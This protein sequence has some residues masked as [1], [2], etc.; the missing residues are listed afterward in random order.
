MAATGLVDLD[1]LVGRDPST[2]A[3]STVETLKLHAAAIGARSLVVSSLRAQYFDMITGNAEASAI[4]QSE[5]WRSTIVLDLRDPRKCLEQLDPANESTI[6]RIAPQLHGLDPRSRTCRTIVEAA[7]ARGVLFLVEG[8]FRTVGDPFLDFSSRAV[9]LDLHFYHLGDFLLVAKGHD[10]AMA[11]TRLLNSP[12]GVER[13]V[14]EL[15]AHRLLF[16]SRCPAFEARAAQARLLGANISGADRD[17]I[18]FR[19]AIELGLA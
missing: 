1:T 4:A 10:N 16:G 19:N 2:T 12:D 9:F 8:D 3:R 7:T 11:T 13:Y 15:G 5:G 6:V 18:A 17:Q 14:S